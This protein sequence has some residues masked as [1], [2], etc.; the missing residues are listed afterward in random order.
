MS[1]TENAGSEITPRLILRIILRLAIVI[2]AFAA[3]LFIPAGRLDW[4]EAW[5]F[6]G[7]FGCFLILYA[8][9]SLLK[10]PAQLQERSKVAEN[11]KSWDKVIMGIYTVLLLV[12]FIVAGL[13]AGRFG[14]TSPA[15]ETRIIA[16]VGLAAGGAL[17]FWAIVANTYLSRMA[18]IQ[19]DRDQQVV[20]SGP[21]RFVRHPMYLGIIVLFLCL[22]LV[23][24]SWW[25]EIPGSLIAVLF[26]VRTALEDRML[27]DELKGY[28]EYARRVHY[29]LFPGIW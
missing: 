1:E 24:G 3:L 22:P 11:V 13:D 18:R 20:T 27:K 23:L 6:V 9:W 17:I 28:M 21:Y 2:G 5:L 25:A 16:W 15:M 19:S 4:V 14:W 10:D 29:R 8:V 12:L 7:V 26:I